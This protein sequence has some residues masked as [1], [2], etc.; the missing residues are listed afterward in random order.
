MNNL[1]VIVEKETGDVVKVVDDSTSN[2]DSNLLSDS[3]LASSASSS[4]IQQGTREP[5]TGCPIIEFT[6]L[7]LAPNVKESTFL[8]TENKNVKACNISAIMPDSIRITLNS[9]DG[10]IPWSSQ[11][12]RY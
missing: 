3:G 10:R 6:A 5:Q 2:S 12:V 11:T 7:N 4:G 9:S 8:G 1:S